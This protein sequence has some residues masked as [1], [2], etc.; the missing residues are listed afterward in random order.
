MLC[1]ESIGHV[2]TRKSR[3]VAAMRRRRPVT[4]CLMLAML[5]SP[6]VTDR[7]NLAGVVVHLTPAAYAQA[8]PTE[9]ENLERGQQLLLRGS[10]LAAMEVLGSVRDDFYRESA[11][12]ALAR[13]HV[14]TGQYDRAVEVLQD[15]MRDA[16]DT[17]EVATALA[18]IYLRTGRSEQANTL[19]TEVTQQLTTPPVR[20]LVQHG[21]VL[22]LRGDRE[23]AQEQF[24]AALA[25]Y[26]SG[27]VFESSD[28]G[29]VA[30]A[31]WQL[32]EFH[33]ANALFNEA[34][35]LDDNNLEALTLWGDL[36]QDKF[37]DEDARR[38]YQQVL[39]INPRY[40]PALVGMGRITSPE[41]NLS[42]ALDVNVRDSEALH[43]FGLIL[44]RNNQREEGVRML[45][46]AVGINPESIPARA[47][48]AALAV[49]NDDEAALAAQRAAINGFSP[50]N[51]M[52][53][54]LAAEFLGNNYRFE[55]AVEYA[56]LAIDSDPQN[57]FAHTVLGGNLVRLGEEA[58]GKG[59]LESAFDNDPFNVLTSNMLQ[60]FDVLEEYETLETEHFRVNMSSRDAQILWPYMAPLLEDSWD[61]LVAKYQ[62]EPEV[63]V[64]IQVFER[65][66][67]FAVRSVGLPDIGPLVGICFG[68]V[69]T[70]ISPD[71][72]SANWQEIV[73]HELV[74][75]WT[76]QMT[77][78]RMPR[79]LSEGISTWEERLGRPEWGRRQ[80]LDLV[81]AVQQQ[82][83]APVAELNNAFTSAGSNADL[84]F[85]YYQSYLVVEYIAEAFGFESLLALIHQY[86]EAK[87]EPEMFE[88][89]FNMD[90][91][92]FDEG[93]QAW[94]QA[95]VE[96]INVY[97]H[98]ED[99]PDDGAAHGHGRRENSSAVLAELYNNQ[100]LKEYMEG[101]VQRQPRDFQ[102]HLQLGI[103]QFRE[104]AWDDAIEHLVI[105]HEILPDYSGY[106]SPPLVLS[107]V[108]EARGDT[109]QQL[110]WL[111]VMLENSQHD[112]AS[113]LK[114]AN[115]ALENGNLERAG[116]YIERALSV[117]P[118]RP[119][120]HQVNAELASALGDTAAA[121]QEYEV[122]L[123][124]D[125]TDPVA[126]RTNL[127]QAYLENNQTEEARQS[128]LRALETAP[129]YERAQQIL[130]RA[131]GRGG[132]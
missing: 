110:Y 27:S 36:F 16:A 107:Q 125:Q 9:L 42:R 24:N 86:A 63:P 68:K 3:R 73:W 28:V 92:S 82:R 45:E 12:L 31:A 59:H 123:V 101:R 34:V 122:L 132:A 131:V 49:M 52:F 71:T 72:L 4:A 37:N 18:E 14:E 84:N 17:P 95:R 98:S 51:S 19:L 5:V 79:W 99:S 93:F 25:R 88:A 91:A 83:V 53:Y 67:D 35:R 124:L 29:M 61:R 54:A 58:E 104:E 116:Y 57:W 77:R 94:L 75:V 8:Q 33:D 80:G 10:Y 43:T 22:S 121:V 74:H 60:V 62:F 109:N 23:A 44:I 13:A 76:L 89:V 21:M 32:D 97:V 40:T 38:N 112:F 129:G 48:L 65:T 26:D 39:D 78:N 41:L 20:S 102:A 50:D 30:L 111:E 115:V 6:L 119:E 128:V 69:I 81:R 96:S 66:E 106:P 1:P 56:R 117:N 126:A 127:A 47:I 118:Y 90:M 113:P 46:Q 105:A 100:S 7:L 108:Y 85:A 114:L 64:V 15:V 2:K 130:L 103:V 11:A 120:I 70:L 87:P 55:E